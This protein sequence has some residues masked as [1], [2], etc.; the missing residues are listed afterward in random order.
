MHAKIFIPLWL[1]LVA[2]FLFTCKK[3]D[4]Q[5]GDYSSVS[6]VLVSNINQTGADFKSSFGQAGV[7]SIIDHGFV[8][9][10][11][12]P[13]TLLNA[14]SISLGVSTGIGSFSV[15]ANSAMETGKTYYVS[16]FVKTEKNI[17]YSDPVSFTSLG[18]A[19][20]TITVIV[21][22]KGIVGDT[23]T[24]RGRNFS[25]QTNVVRFNTQD[26][27]V[28]SATDTMLRV[29]VPSSKGVE[30]AEVSVK[31]SGQTVT[32]RSFT[33]LKPEI[34]DFWPKTGIYLDTVYVKERNYSGRKVIPTLMF[35]DV[36][37]NIILVKD[38]VYKI[39]VSSSKGNEKVPIVFSVDDF[40]N[41]AGEFFTYRIPVI[42]KIDPAEGIN[43]DIVRIKGKDFGYQPSKVKI[44]FGGKDA[45]MIAATDTVITVIAPVVDAGIENATITAVVDERTIICPRQFRY[46]KPVITSFEPQNACG[47]DSIVIRG[48]YFLSTDKINVS[49]GSYSVKEF[50]KITDTE[51]RA[52][53]PF[54]TGGEEVIISV[55]N[56]GLAGNTENK[57]QYMK[58]VFT[59]FNPKN[60]IGNDEVII[61]GEHFGN[62][63]KNFTVYFGNDKAEILSFG[64]SQ[65]KVKVPRYNNV[66]SVNMRIIRD[67]MQVI[68]S[69]KY[70]YMSPVITDFNPKTGI[71][72]DEI[73][74]DGNYF[75]G[76][77]QF[78]DLYVYIDNIYMYA[79]SLSNNQIKFIVPSYRGTKSVE[80]KVTREGMTTLATLPFVYASP[81]ITSFAPQTGRSGDEIVINGSNFS[82]NPALVKVSMENS[83]LTIVSCSRN[84]LIVKLPSGISSGLHPLVVTVDNQS[85]T[86][87]SSFQF[88]GPWTRKSSIPTEAR[89]FPFAYS[90]NGEG[91]VGMGATRFQ[92]DS[93][94]ETGDTWKYNP[95]NDTWTQVNNSADKKRYSLTFFQIADR[96]YMGGGMINGNPF[97]D[98]YESDAE[99]ISWERKETPPHPT[100]SGTSSFVIDNKAYVCGGVFGRQVWQYDPSTDQWMRKADLP[101]DNRYWAFAF[102]LNGKG[103]FAC[104]KVS[105]NT[106]VQDLW[107]YNTQT[108]RWTKLLD[109]F[110]GEFTA[111]A[112]CFKINGKVYAGLGEFVGT[113]WSIRKATRDIWEYDP[114]RISWKYVTTIPG[115]GGLGA[116]VFVIGDKAYIGGGYE[117]NKETTTD[118]YEFD[119]SKL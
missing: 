53:I 48:R 41:A 49:F 19:A 3:D 71:V 24:I 117:Y 100:M 72:G 9:G 36:Q 51:I 29:R 44:R 43:G 50:G 22:E 21:P 67:G 92:V 96:I 79:S 11:A 106:F 59:D 2:L 40:M 80:L 68:S 35:G 94:G 32:N 64:T 45:F 81:E 113:Y 77:K 60:G 103:Y 83:Q 52:V 98:F 62:A 6:S 28:L 116:Y 8:Y 93:Q 12:T 75:G 66:T 37:A 58:P 95:G 47:G 119:P 1:L 104:G 27:S 25:R 16:A 87:L 14:E 10:T 112:I 39:V 73:T 20:P 33:Y 102:D 15:R 23:V 110:P 82:N 114:S 86:S 101:E 84:Q 61:E 76:E 108:N 56:N 78:K 34:I 88:S 74:I 17:Y 63:V 31:T 42:S 107:E 111:G 69:A 54:S 30:I 109:E 90:Y 65:I 115:T 97:N 85:Y 105:A 99:N 26:A 118:F 7:E 70:T 89:T 91:Y 18:S 4:G 5:S 46:Q 57:F 38:S 55:K 13:P